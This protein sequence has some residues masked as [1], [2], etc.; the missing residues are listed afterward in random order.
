MPEPRARLPLA[1]IGGGSIGLRHAGVAMASEKVTLTAVVEPDA[2]R[3]AELAGLGLPAVAT[4]DAVPSET[5]AAV[6]ATP[7]PDH[8][9]SGTAATDRGW[10]VLV[11]KPLAG[12]LAGADRLIAAARRAGLPLLTGHH[13]RCHP[14]VAEARLRLA[15]IGDLVAVQGLWSLRKH[16]GYFDL[17]WRKRPGAGPLLTNLSHDIDLIRH[18][19]GEIAEVSALTSTAA[20]GGPLEDT[21]TVQFRFASGALGAFLLSDAGASPWAFEAATGENPDLAASGQDYLRLIGSAGSLSFPSLVLWQSAAGTAP[22]WRRPMRAEPAQLPER[23]DPI[24]AQID[25][26]AAVVAG[27]PDPELA[28]GP[29]GRATLAATLAAAL[30]AA[31]RAPVAPEDVPA[32]Y[33]GWE[34]TD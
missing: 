2:A 34:D 31:T 14:F 25:R 29:D 28:D 12:T 7:T 26:F 8:A 13:R 16:A 11:E 20:R 17:P 19:A 22:D 15:R 5:R 23:I 27:R 30:S 10:P 24:A 32:D 9:A 18:L 6:V 3:R 1:V 21:A 33:P 4:L